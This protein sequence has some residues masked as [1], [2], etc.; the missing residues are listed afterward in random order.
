MKKKI[1][2]LTT[3][4]TVA[5]ATVATFLR[6]RKPKHKISKKEMAHEV[7]HI[8]NDFDNNIP[9]HFSVA[10]IFNYCEFFGNAVTYTVQCLANETDTNTQDW[11][12]MDNSEDCQTCKLAC[13]TI[14]DTLV[15]V[16]YDSV[17]DTVEL[18]NYEVR[19]R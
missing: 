12:V 6:D 17:E 2:V 14:N 7:L 18:T 11:Y 10:S 19:V 9:V 1:I 16:C 5:G 13:T 4:I 15:V 8:P 3:L